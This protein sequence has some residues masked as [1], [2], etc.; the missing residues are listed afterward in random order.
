MRFRSWHTS[1]RQNAKQR[2]NVLARLVL[3]LSMLIDLRRSLCTRKVG[4]GRRRVFGCL[5]SISQ[6]QHRKYLYMRNRRHSTMVQCLETVQDN[7]GVNIGVNASRRYT[8]YGDGDRVRCNVIMC[9]MQYWVVFYSSAEAPLLFVRTDSYIHA[10]TAWTLSIH[11][12][13]IALKPMTYAAG[14]DTAITYVRKPR[15]R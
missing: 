2:T 5:Y 13:I 7:I 15:G 12:L 1:I 4:R 11:P 10:C 6:G 8:I 14:Y 3:C 9:W